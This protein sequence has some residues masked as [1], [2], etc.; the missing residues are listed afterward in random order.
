M[1]DL[2][3]SKN[4]WSI[5]L[6]DILTPS[7][8]N[9][10]RN[11]FNEAVT[12]CEQTHE[13]T[14]YLMTF[15]NLLGVIPQWSN[16]VIKTECDNIIKTSGCEHLTDLIT[17]V[18]IVQLK[19]MT[20]MRSNTKQKAIN[21]PIPDIEPF[22]HNIYIQTARQL[23][24]CVYLFITDAEPLEMQKNAR[25]VE[26][27]VQNSILKIIRDSIPVNIIMDTYLESE[28]DHEEEVTIEPIQTETSDEQESN[29]IAPTTMNI[30]TSPITSPYIS[31]GNSPHPSSE[32]NVHPTNKTAI[33]YSEPA[34]I[35]LQKPQS[36]IANVVAESMNVKWDENI[37]DTAPNRD[38]NNT[39]EFDTSGTS[40]ISDFQ[41][42]EFDN[43]SQLAQ[44]SNV[45]DLNIETM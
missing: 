25:E 5:K 14:K 35:P 3:T 31:P 45:T 7:I 10:I 40:S 18:H 43:N 22:I 4:E 34:A 36:P 19:I 32:N 33:D 23:Y 37:H 42:E 16:T 29:I 39:I 20:S 6:I 44:Q 38:N 15:Q 24:K 12:L 1:E 13:T 17:C 26:T 11:I 9:G 8:I 41:I 2:Q 21:I 28:V 30:G 27:I